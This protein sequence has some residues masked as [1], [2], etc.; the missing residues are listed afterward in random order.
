MEPVLTTAHTPEATIVGRILKQ[1]HQQPGALLPILHAVQDALGHIPDWAVAHI[2]SDLNRSRAE[3]HGVVSFY[4]HFR[5]TPPAPHQLHI[6]QAEAC[7][8]R[9]AR[10]LTRHAQQALGCGMHERSADGNVELEPVYCLGLC[11]NGPALQLDARQHA[12]V[13]PE[14]LDALLQQTREAR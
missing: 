2:A 6:C 11:A 14:R 13:D 1:H 5:T 8:A 9:G 10:E 12:A 4:H 7:Q 3:I